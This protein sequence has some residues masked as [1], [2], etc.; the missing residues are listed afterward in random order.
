MIDIEILYIIHNHIISNFLT[1]QK[2]K[3]FEK[4]F[5]NDYWLI[6]KDIYIYHD[7]K[8]AKAAISQ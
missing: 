8:N 2:L 6:V 3:L 7:H 5:L 1:A 4:I